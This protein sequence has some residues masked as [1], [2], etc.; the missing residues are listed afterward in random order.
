MKKTK[1]I[2]SL[3]TCCF[4]LSILAFGVYAMA[5]DIQLKFKG[6]IKFEAPC[7]VY[8]NEVRVFLLN[9]YG[10]KIEGDQ[11]TKVSITGDNGDGI[12]GDRLFNNE[13]DIGNISAESGQ[14]VEID[15]NMS[16][17][18]ANYLKVK[19]AYKIPD[20]NDYSKPG[21]KVRSNR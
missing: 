20:N 9:R 3:I 10:D 8:I 11:G 12:W 1:L 16:S 21:T 17:I 15:I 19:L 6:T 5:T 2:M 7:G 18:C 14:K 13:L 4:A